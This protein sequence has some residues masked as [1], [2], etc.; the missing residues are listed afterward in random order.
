MV[1]HK[2]QDQFYHLHLNYIKFINLISVILT[3]V[4]KIVGSIFNEEILHWGIL[5]PKPKNILHSIS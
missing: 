1:R 3:P 2:F 4:F 5:K